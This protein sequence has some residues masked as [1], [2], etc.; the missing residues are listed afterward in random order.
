MVYNVPT[1]SHGIPK[2][3]DLALPKRIDARDRFNSV[4]LIMYFHFDKAALLRLPIPESQCQ[5]K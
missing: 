1:T 3:C 4:S 5:C 2:Q